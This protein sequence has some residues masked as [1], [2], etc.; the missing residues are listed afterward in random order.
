VSG[1]GAKNPAVQHLRRLS[2]RRSARTE[3]GCF[4]I[5]GPV[6]VAEALGA[7][8]RLEAVYVEQGDDG[9]VASELHAL[10]DQAEQRGAT[11]HDLYPG[12]LA[13]AVDTVT[14]HG[15]AAIGTLPPSRTDLV[16]VLG[17][18]SSTVEARQG[19]GAGPVLVLAGV[20]DPGNAGTLLRSAEAAGARAVVATAG[21]VDLFAPK[22]V[23]SSAGSLF[24]VPVVVDAAID[25]LLLGLAG[26]DITTVGTAADAPAP[27]DETDLTIPI[28]VVLGNE[29][30][31]LDPAVAAQ[32]DTT[33]SIPMDGAVESLNVAMAGTLLLFEAARQRRATT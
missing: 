15:I 16:G 17:A 26:A 33:V 31:G 11:R 32:L 4:V 1:L 30:H 19:G 27:Y 13:G 8:L 22:V 2:R 18:T 24:R 9:R 28:A 5:D 21:S 14:P 10:A 7:G 6:L 25:D 20:S 3:S 23:R 29:A 12:V